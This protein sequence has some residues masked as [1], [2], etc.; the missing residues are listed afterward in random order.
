MTT[1]V[2]IEEVMKV[3]DDES[4]FTTGACA[5]TKDGRSTDVTSDYAVCWCLLGAISR[6]SAM[7]PRVTAYSQPYRDMQHE[8]MST[9]IDTQGEYTGITVFSDNSGYE[10]V[11]KMLRRT[12][13]RLVTA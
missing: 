2:Y 7:S 4:K 10:A 13:A 9:I 3:L 12:H 1:A 6:V 5:R 11:M 8:V